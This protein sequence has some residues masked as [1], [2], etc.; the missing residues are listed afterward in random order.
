ME[1]I[2][3]TCPI[4]CHLTVEKLADNKLA[5][6]GN[7]CPRGEKYAYEELLEPKRVVCTTVRIAKADVDPSFAGIARLPVRTDK[8]FPKERI[9]DLLKHLH[10]MEVKL[11]VKRGTVVVENA[12]GTGINVIATRTIH[13][14]QQA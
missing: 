1:L 8:A 9:Q 12:M 4:G 10:S 7:R 6:S 2:C 5:V 14:K 11:P 3:I 13:K